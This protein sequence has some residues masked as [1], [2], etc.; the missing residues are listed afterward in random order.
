MIKSGIY[1]ILNTI[2]GKFYIGSAKL[3]AKR[4]YELKKLK[5]KEKTETSSIEKIA[6]MVKIKREEDEGL[7][8]STLPST[9]SSLP[10]AV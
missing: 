10:A 8:M 1:K 2:N 6:R 5:E 4:F 9:S 7:E 3:L